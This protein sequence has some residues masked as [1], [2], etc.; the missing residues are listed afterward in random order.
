MDNVKKA[1][2]TPKKKSL[3]FENA[4][5]GSMEIDRETLVKNIETEH[6]SYANY[7]CTIDKTK[8][9]NLPELAE[10]YPS[11]FSLGIVIHLKD[12]ANPEGN[13]KT[14]MTL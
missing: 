4:L 14:T 6:R 13:K 10:Q 2:E 8:S 5:I 1:V 7:A 3:T 9:F 11:G 12:N